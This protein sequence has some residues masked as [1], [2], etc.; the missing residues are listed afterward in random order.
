MLY[1]STEY[2]YNL[3]E[4]DAKD[5]YVFY[6][7]K[8]SEKEKSISNDVIV[9]RDG[10]GKYTFEDIDSDND[11]LNDFKEINGG[12]NGLIKISTNFGECIVCHNRKKESVFFPCGHRCTCYICA[13]LIFASEKKCPKCK[14]ETICIIRKVYE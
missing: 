11:G 1:D 3:S 10:T 9:N 14:K 6:I 13:N 2:V 12:D 8:C 5:K 7:K 4:S